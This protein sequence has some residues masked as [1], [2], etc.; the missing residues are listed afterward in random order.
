MTKAISLL[1]GGLDS[2]LATL[3]VKNLGIE[4]T[5]V[6]FMTPFGCDASDRSSCSG[7]ALPAAEKFGFPIKMCNLGSSFMEIV[8]NPRHGYGRNMNP[9]IDCRILMLREAKSL[10]D[11]TGADFLVTGE[12]V[13]QRPMSQKKHTLRL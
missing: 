12:V 4:V 1:S 2:T 6:T 9:C 10:M 8:R 5:A 13:G 11:M 7:N 3:I